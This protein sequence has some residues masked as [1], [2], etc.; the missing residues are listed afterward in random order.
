MFSPPNCDPQFM[1]LLRSQRLET[2]SDERTTVYGLWPDFR[3]AF[4]N[5]GWRKFSSENGGDPQIPSQWQIGRSVMEAIRQ[6]LQEFFHEQFA[7]CLAENRPWD[8]LYE[9]STPD[10]YRLFHMRVVPLGKSEGL[11][12]VH[13]PRYEQ[14]LKTVV[15]EDHYRQLNGLVIQCSYCRRVRPKEKENEWHWVSD[16]GRRSP[17]QTSHGCC[18][19]CRA[20]YLTPGEDGSE[21]LI[22]SIKTTGQHEVQTQ[23]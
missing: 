20:I 5:S 1:S 13:S 21:I 23:G 17:P 18:H 9:C 15:I 16:W 10:L 7:R 3:L 22:E 12:A 4:V 14:N 6:P 2:L 11:L 19:L 8:H